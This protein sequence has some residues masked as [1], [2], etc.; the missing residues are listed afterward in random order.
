MGSEDNILSYK[1]MKIIGLTGGIGSGKS[2][3]LDFF[4]KKGF[5]CYNSDKKARVLVNTNLKLKRKIKKYFGESIYRL[6]KIDSKALSKIVFSKPDDLKRLNSLI[7]P[8]VAEDFLKFTLDNKASIIFKESAILFESGGH[9]LCDFTILIKAPIKIRIDR[10][11]KRDKIDI[12]LVKSK[13]SNQWSDRKKSI[14]ADKVVKNID[15]NET[16]MLLEK[17]LIELKLKFNI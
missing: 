2:K 13:I 1:E 16:V 7:H 3:V 4:I 17:L 5:P 14:L 9:S 12:G 6:G 8:V 15:W 11:I 10:V